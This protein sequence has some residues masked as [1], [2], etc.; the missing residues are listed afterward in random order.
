MHFGIWVSENVPET[1]FLELPFTYRSPIPCQNTIP[2][3]IWV[4]MENFDP[5]QIVVFLHPFCN[6]LQFTPQGQGI[7]G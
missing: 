2:V 6:F 3:E 7:K 5:A 1:D 4:S